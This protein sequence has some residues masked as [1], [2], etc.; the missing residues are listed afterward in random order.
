MSTLKKDI[1]VVFTGGKPFTPAVTKVVVTEVRVPVIPTVASTG[2]K[3][4]FFSGTST[5]TNVQN[6]GYAFYMPVPR[7]QAGQGY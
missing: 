4:N 5:A 6:N 2:T 7:A 3:W 1:D